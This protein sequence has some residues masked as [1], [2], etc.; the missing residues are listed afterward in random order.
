MNLIVHAWLELD[1][2]LSV[3]SSVGLIERCTGIAG[4]I[5]ARRSVNRPLDASVTRYF[6]KQLLNKHAK[7]YQHVGKITKFLLS[8]EVMV[9]KSI[10]HLSK[11]KSVKHFPSL[12]LCFF[13]CYS[14]SLVLFDCNCA[15]CKCDA[16]MIGP[17]VSIILPRSQQDHAKILS[18]ILARSCQ[19][20]T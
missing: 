9:S 12:K 14:F 16:A 13:P 6:A 15:K 7:N 4:S 20:L 17:R 19:D 10:K 3:C 5:P 2:C 11:T 8:T 1:N 18:K